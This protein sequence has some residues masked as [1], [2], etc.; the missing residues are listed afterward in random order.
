MSKKLSTK[1]RALLASV[2]TV[3]PSP[4]DILSV[5]SGPEL[6][7]DVVPMVN[8]VVRSPSRPRT[9][10]GIAS[11]QFF[12]N[13]ETAAENERLKGQLQ[14]FDGA[15][16]TKKLDPK[17]IKRSKWANRDETGLTDENKDYLALK[18]EIRAAGGNVQPIK[19]RPITGTS[20]QQY[21]VVFG[22]RRLK[23]CLDLGLDVLAMIESLDDKALF[24]EMD[25]ENRQRA[26]LRPYEQ[27][28]MYAYALDNAMFSSMRK[29]ADE[30]G[31][32]HPNISVAVAIARFPEPV[33]NAFESRL[34]IQFRWA[35]PL[36]SAIE[37][38]PDVVLALANEI[39]L[40]REAGQGVA[41][42]DVFKKLAG[43]E[44]TKVEAT[45]KVVKSGD[46]FFTVTEKGDHISFAFDKLERA[47]RGQLE[48]LIK[49]FLAA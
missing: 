48:K 27:G 32:K 26:D 18:D 6:L 35:A 22:H 8:V 1:E 21:E 2:P 19:V 43:L 4:A 7:P 28:V 12:K 33:L 42:A 16:A 40:Q 10:I 38:D 31:V 5:E 36:A 17:L 9:A 44:R 3:A 23:A 13:D 29:M 37:K 30:I 25:R 41:S 45:S 34:D 49:E 15:S 46:K 20:P 14:E 47:K 39:A 11:G 24:I